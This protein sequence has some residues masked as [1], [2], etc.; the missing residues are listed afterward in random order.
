MDMMID[1]VKVVAITDLE[2]E[3]GVSDYKVTTNKKPQ[4]EADSSLQLTLY[5]YMRKQKKVRLDQI[6]KSGGGRAERTY[7]SRTPGDFK[8]MTTVL[9]RAWAVI[10]SG[11]FAPCDPTSWVCTPKWCGWY[12]MCR[13]AHYSSGRKK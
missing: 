4:S 12:K 2:D 1:G 7:S 8:W 13:G 3:A 10:T 11:V 6:I 9:Q 5:S